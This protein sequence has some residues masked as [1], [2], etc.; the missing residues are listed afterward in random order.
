MLGTGIGPLHTTSDLLREQG[1]VSLFAR[2]VGARAV[3]VD[4]AEGSG[5]LC[6]TGQRGQQEWRSVPDPDF[7][8]GRP[9]SET[10]L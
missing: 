10:R 1:D 6:G 7:G 9:G 4:R 8:F 5:S 3:M 2:I